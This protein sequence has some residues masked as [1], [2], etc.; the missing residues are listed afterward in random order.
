[1]P[2]TFQHPLLIH[3]ECRWLSQLQFHYVEE[4]AARNFSAYVSTLL[5]ALCCQM[6]M[7]LANGWRM[8]LK[9]V[10]SYVTKMH[11]AATVEGIYC[12]D[13]M[14]YQVANSFLRT[15]HPLAPEIFFQLSNIKM[16]CMDKLT[17]QFR[18][19]HPSQENT[20]VVYQLYL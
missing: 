2:S 11:D 15:V 14:G 20:N 16:V 19:T 8:L 10:F 1:M 4:D 7:Q 9:H 12:R 5:G 6:D 17:K 13:V 18:I 3:S